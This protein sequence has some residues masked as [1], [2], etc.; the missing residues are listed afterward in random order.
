MD[1]ELTSHE[2]IR[3][4]A[5]QIHTERSLTFEVLAQVVIRPLASHDPGRPLGRILGRNAQHAC[6]LQLQL[7]YSNVVWRPSFLKQAS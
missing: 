5:V 6:M 3:A 7:T 1:D 2:H 4:H